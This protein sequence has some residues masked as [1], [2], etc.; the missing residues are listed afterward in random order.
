M[1]SNWDRAIWD[2]DTW[3]YI[4]ELDGTPPAW[5]ND[6]YNVRRAISFDPL[7]FL[8]GSESRLSVTVTQEE[9]RTKGGIKGLLVVYAQDGANVQE[10]PHYIV[11][12]NSLESTIVFKK[13]TPVTKSTSH[14]Y[15]FYYCYPMAVDLPIPPGT[16]LD[17]NELS[18]QDFPQTVNSRLSLTKPTV[19]WA[20]GRSNIPGAKAVFVFQGHL[21]GIN[22]KHGPDKGAAMIT[23][24]SK[25]PVIIDCYSSTEQDVYHYVEADNEVAEHRV[26]IN[27]TGI[28]SP[29]ATD[30][31]VEITDIKYNQILIGEAQEEEFKAVSRTSYLVGV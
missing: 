3:F 27:V 9:M 22:F 11:S 5:W 20:N 24:D 7:E 10:V 19:D 29:A 15:Y 2:H 26:I 30:C 8:P 14:Q 23:V 21:L 6:N 25:D 4:Q 13:V 1:S 16:G 31:L 17:P 18:I 12:P 28:K